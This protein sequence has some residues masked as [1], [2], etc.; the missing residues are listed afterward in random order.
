MVAAN[1]VGDI[2]GHRG[3]QG[4]TGGNWTQGV[5]PY[6]FLHFTGPGV[7]IWAAVPGICRNVVKGYGAIVQVQCGG[8]RHVRGGAVLVEV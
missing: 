8:R 5:V 3:Q 2:W 6:Q 7:S 4:V 1:V